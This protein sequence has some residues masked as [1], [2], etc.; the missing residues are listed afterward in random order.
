MVLFIAV[1]IGVWAED[2]EDAVISI[3][4]VHV[5]RNLAANGDMAVIFHWRWNSGNTLATTASDT[6][7]F[8]YLNDGSVISSA[9]PYD[10]ILF[11]NDGYGDGVTGFY[12]ADNS[13]WGEASIIRIAGLPAYYDPPPVFEYHMNAY[14]YSSSTS[15]ADNREDLK[16]YILDLCDEFHTIYPAVSLKTLTDIGTVLSSYGE[17]YFMSAVPGLQTLCPALFFVQSYVPQIMEVEPYNMLLAAK[18]TA[19]MVGTD[20]QKGA[21]RAG[22]YVGVSGNVFWGILVF[23]GCLGIVIT[24]QK[25]GWLFEVTLA[26]CGGIVIGASLLIGDFLFTIVM[27]VALLAIIGISFAFYGKRS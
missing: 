6:V 23:A 8:T 10:Y 13:T 17:A 27:V 14:D 11:N 5:Y 15:Q 12:L 18:Y 2:P 7:L 20:L 22:A 16:L 19:R 1:P 26:I 3:Q 4:S 25:R 9:V 21:E 24:T